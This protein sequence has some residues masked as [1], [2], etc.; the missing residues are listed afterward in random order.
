MT[1]K[2][3][4]VQSFISEVALKPRNGFH[5][6]RLASCGSIGLRESPCR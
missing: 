3:N 5:D 1:P 4:A 2:A 6:E